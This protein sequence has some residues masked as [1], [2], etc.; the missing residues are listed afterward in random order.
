MVV[1][2]PDT[3]YLVFLGSR[4]HLLLLKHPVNVPFG[5]AWNHKPGS[6]YTLNSAAARE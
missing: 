6:S 1:E 4:N 2:A 5:Y 3:L